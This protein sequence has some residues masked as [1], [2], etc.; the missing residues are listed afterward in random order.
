MKVLILYNPRAGRC[1]AHKHSSKLLKVIN[2][3]YLH[4]T[5]TEYASNS[6]E[7]MHKYLL[8]I[9][10]SIDVI[11][12]IGGDGTLGPT[13]NALLQNN[14]DIPV[15]CYGR[16][17]ANDF[18][19]FMKT[20]CRPRRAAKIITANKTSLVDTLL[21]NESTYAINVACGGA[22]TNG[23]TRYNKKSKRIFGKLAYMTHAAW[24]ALRL[25]SQAVEFTIDGDTV[26]LNVYLFYILNSKNVGGLRNSC[27]VSS[28]SDGVL[29]LICIKK[30]GFFGKVSVAVSQLRGRMHLNK[31]VVHKCGRDF[32]VNPVG[33]ITPNFTLTDTDGNSADPYPLRVTV[34]RQIRV[35]HKN[36]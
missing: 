30:C 18:A 35:V 16:G 26:Q 22:F 20:N 17:T 2:R 5:V 4:V 19:S 10:R 1:R 12:V 9:D 15:Y 31:N 8:T 6:I 21:V 33:D 32:F 25:K 27:P 36:N 13:V 3:S 29:D 11:V 14:I 24:I 28:I 23:V 7:D 34:G